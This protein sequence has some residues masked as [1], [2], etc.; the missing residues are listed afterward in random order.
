V[1]VDPGRIADPVTPDVPFE[2]LRRNARALLGGLVLLIVLAVLLPDL[3]PPPTQPPPVEL[4]RGRIVELIPQTGGAKAPDVRIAVLDG[5]L[6]GQTVEGFLQGPSGEQDLPRYQV[7]DE[8]VVNVSTEPGATFIAVADLYRIPS[9]A[10]L[11][12]I[13]ALAGRY[14]T[15]SRVDRPGRQF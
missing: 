14:G 13:F 12:A 2:G 11:L 6:K 9:L 4:L 7:G 3:T 15:D 8:V 5:A 1:T 10:L